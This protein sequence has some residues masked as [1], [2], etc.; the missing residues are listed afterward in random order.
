[1]RRIL[2]FVACLLLLQL[3]L[4]A[5]VNTRGPLPYGKWESTDP[6]I[7]MDINPQAEEFLGIYKQEDEEI[8]VYIAFSGFSKQFDIYKISDKIYRSQSGYY[9]LALFGGSYR[10]RSGKLN[11]KLQPYW[12]EKSGITHT[13]VFTKIEEY[14]IPAE[15]DGP[16]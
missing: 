1:M 12:Q 11:Y 3:C 6:H 8:E 10:V 2:V 9:R 14:E 7:I 4:S 16:N 15:E 13:I 5:C